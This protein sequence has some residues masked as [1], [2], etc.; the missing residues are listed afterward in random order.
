MS[1]IS[2]APIVEGHG[3]WASVRPLLYRVWVELLGGEHVEILPPI[4]RS[5][6]RLI[7]AATG[8]LRNAV[9]FA[10]RKL[11]LSPGP[12]LVLVLVDAEDDCRT[13]G[14]LGPP[15]L[16]VARAARP[17]VDCACVVANVMYETWF[18][19]AAES[20]TKYL[21]LDGTAIPDD[22]DESHL[23]KGWI[24]ERFRGTNYSET[25]DQPRLT[26]AMDLAM[27]RRRSRSFDKLCRELEKR[28]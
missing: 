16:A 8:E 4:R 2:I 20:L 22:A 19:A 28:L 18:V 12:S 6:G 21:D 23:G 9:D 25:V 5:R 27:A 17:D 11:R 15:L 10:A 13:V 14:S 24:K 26:A 3:E 7:K 1:R